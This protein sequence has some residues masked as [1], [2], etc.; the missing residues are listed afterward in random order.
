MLM[1]M[2]AAELTRNIL[3]EVQPVHE[4][5]FGKSFTAAV[6]ECEGLQQKETKVEKRKKRRVQQ[7]SRIKFINK[8]VRLMHWMS[9]QR[10]FH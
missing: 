1:D 4:K 9:C 6:S 8:C 7:E 10:A 3:S 2:S 5:A